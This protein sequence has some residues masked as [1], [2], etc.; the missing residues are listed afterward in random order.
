MKA[1]VTGACGFIGHH[2]TRSL[3]DNGVDVVGVDLRTYAASA[4]SQVDGWL[5]GQLYLVDVC[6]AETMASLVKRFRPDVVFHLAAESHVDASLQDP[7]E[8]MR[9]N[10]VG[11]QVVGS[12]CASLDVPLVYCSTD[13]VYG[14]VWG[15]PRASV[16]S[17]ALHPSSPYSAGKAAGEMALWALARSFGLRAVITRG[18][19]AYG[20]GQYPEK[21]IPIAC[22]LLQRGLPVGLHGG[23]HQV[24]QWVHVDE[25]VVGLRR[26]GEYLLRGE[27]PTGELVPT[28]NIAGP[29][30]L[31]VLAL[32]YALADHLGV[33]RGDAVLKVA[34]RPGQDRAYWVDG[35]KS[36]RLLGLTPQLRVLDDVGAL[37]EAYPADGSVVVA[38]WSRAG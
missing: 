7:A 9:V 33:D 14:D 12:V 30:R 5:A 2:L 16:E 36:A 19:N 17:D 15:R 13:E 1:I 21:L 31:S 3:L 22:R 4:W 23:G 10:A 20:P 11:T 26:A 34:D 35:A 29:S 27:Q 6:H 24:R 25:F 37:L 38:D 8:A 32:V 28:F 18:C